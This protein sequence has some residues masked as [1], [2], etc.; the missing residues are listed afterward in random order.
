MIAPLDAESFEAHAAEIDR[1]EEAS[2]EPSRRDALDLL[3]RLAAEPRGACHLALVAGRVAGFVLGAPLERFGHVAGVERD[4]TLG[5][6]LTLYVVDLTVAAEHRGRGIARALKMA[7]LDTARTLG[8]RWVSGRNRV[9]LADAMWRLNVS[10]GARE[11]YRIDDAY[12]DGPP[13]RQAIYY[14]ITLDLAPIGRSRE[15]HVEAGRT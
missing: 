14:Q 11:L 8:Y 13:P 4:N 2:Y 10:L 3:A 12:P 7:Q 5:Q 9:G 6:G 15:G 1:I